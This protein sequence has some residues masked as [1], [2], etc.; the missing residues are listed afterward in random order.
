MASFSSLSDHDLFFYLKDGEVGA[1]KE[2]FDR[3]DRLLFIYAYKK[4]KDKED[5]KDVVQDIFTS[6]WNNR[7]TIIIKNAL[8]VY[9]YTSVRNKALNLFRDRQINNKYLKTLQDFINRSSDATDHRVREQDI[10]T[11]IDNEIARLPA[12]MREVFEL[13]RNAHMSNKEIAEQLSISEHTVATHIKRALKT[14]R[15]RLGLVTYLIFL[16]YY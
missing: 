9:L 16:L 1:F 15:I 8:Q 10:K 3:Y 13:R 12:K 7:E 2:I 6:L 5:A 11:L 4:L 14:L